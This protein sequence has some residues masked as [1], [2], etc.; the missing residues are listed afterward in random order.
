MI[1]AVIIIFIF[2]VC[3]NLKECNNITL[4]HTLICIISLEYDIHWDVYLLLFEIIIDIIAPW[5]IK[6]PTKLVQRFSSFLHPSRSNYARARTCWSQRMQ[7]RWKFCTS[8]VNNYYNN[9]EH[10]R[11]LMMDLW[12]IVINDMKLYYGVRPQGYVNA[13]FGV[14]PGAETAL[15]A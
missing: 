8:C 2:K 1:I 12:C 10:F 4:V 3:N 9:S 13:D 5:Y 14:R 6:L 11:C 15:Q 7:E